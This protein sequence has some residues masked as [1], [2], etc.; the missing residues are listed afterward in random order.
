MSERV[1]FEVV[2]ADPGTEL[3]LVD[4]DLALVKRGVGRETFSIPPGIYKI[5]A[6]SG[7]TATEEMIVVHEG[8][9]TVRLDPA[10]LASPMPLA[11]SAKTHEFHM[12]VAHDA[13]ATPTLTLG[14]GSA[15]V[16]VARQWTGAN[17]PAVAAAQLPN[18][19]R[20]LALRDMSGRVIADVEG[21]TRVKETFDPCVAVHVALDPGAYRLTL[22]YGNGRRVE[23]MLI[24]CAGWQT[25]AYLLLDDRPSAEARV[26]LVNGAITMRRPSE[27]FNSDD[28]RLRLEEIARGALYDDRKIL[29]ADLRALITSPEAPPMLALLG[30]HLLI[31]EAKDAKARKEGGADE[32]MEVVDNRP[33][34]RRIVENLRVA[35]GAHPDVEAIAIGAGNA[36]PSYVFEAPPLFRGSWRL[37]LKA[38]VQQPNLLP[39]GSFGARVA[40]RIWGEGPWLLWHDPDAKATVDRSVLWQTTARD[41]LSSLR[42]PEGTVAAAGVAQVARSVIG[43]PSPSATGVAAL[44][45][46][47]RSFFTR[48]SRRPFPDLHEAVHRV[49]AAKDVVA[50]A[51]VRA[52][53]SEEQRRALVK[54]L[55]V[56][57]SSIDAWLAG[58]ER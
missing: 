1:T 5:K 32:G 40:E 16:I 15:I 29:S 33:A 27:G 52:V 50:L 8:M 30:A 21:L 3:F 19:A 58:L 20:G 49:M 23:Q 53:L 12:S 9:A 47:V 22:A 42:F 55:G 25:H 13:A 34:V 48:R 43:T 17:P 14:A 18:P 11:H 41:I 2:A 24:C 26:D 39:A 4:G 57:M 45:A 31:R 54:R 51:G 44:A 6:R 28:P 35:I 37:L 56:P 38:S 7:R 36:D 46:K 10:L